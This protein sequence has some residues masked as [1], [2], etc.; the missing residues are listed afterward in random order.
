MKSAENPRM[1]LRSIA[2]AGATRDR[3]LKSAKDALDAVADECIAAG[4]RV[5]VK[6][7]AQ[8]AGVSRGALIKRIATRREARA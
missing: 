7:A 3:G 4:E 2:R 1:D 5:N 8:T 6:L